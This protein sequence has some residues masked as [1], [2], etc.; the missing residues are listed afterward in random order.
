MTKKE[1]RKKCK[2]EKSTSYKLILLGGIFAVL[3]VIVVV[4][5]MVLV[6]SFSAQIIGYIT[7]VVIAAIGMSLDLAGEVQLSNDYKAY[8]SKN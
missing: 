6:K 2:E 3:G 5:T 8:N 4:A 7:G 1:F